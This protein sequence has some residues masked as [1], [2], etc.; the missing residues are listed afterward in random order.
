MVVVRFARISPFRFPAALL[1]VLWAVLTLGGLFAGCASPDPKPS[2]APAAPAHLTV[3]NQTD[4]AWHLVVRRSSGA[5]A[6]DFR[7]QARA[8]LSIDLAAGDYVIEQ[9]ELSADAGPALSR[10][11]PTQLV[12][13]QTYR[14]RLATLLSEPGAADSSQP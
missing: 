3:I 12:A 9:T 14:W 4:Y 2:S 7:V 5:G 8:T 13:G 11:I 10:Q 6:G 1:R